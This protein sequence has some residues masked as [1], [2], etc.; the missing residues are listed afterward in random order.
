MR[1]ILFLCFFLMASLGQTQCDFENIGSWS[2]PRS[3]TLAV[4]EQHLYLNRGGDLLIASRDLTGKLLI[5]GELD[6]PGNIEHILPEGDRLWIASGDYGL[7]LVDITDPTLPA[8]NSTINTPGQALDFAIR[9]QYAYIADGANGLLI[10]DLWNPQQPVEVGHIPFS[11][12]ATDVAISD[13][14]AYLALGEGGIGVVDISNPRRA[15][16]GSVYPFD[17]PRKTSRN[18]RGKSLRHDAG[19][20]AQSVFSGIVGNTSRAR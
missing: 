6:L 4:D 16:L 13:D 9:D 10:L 18:R 15:Q 3:T 17:Q 8:L 2:P 12:A 19:V 14:F 11:E 20:W 1:R 5:L 7:F